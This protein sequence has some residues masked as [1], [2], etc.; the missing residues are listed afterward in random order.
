[1]TWPDQEY[2][3]ST[4]DKLISLDKLDTRVVIIH[5]FKSCK[6][7]E[8]LI[9]DKVKTYIQD[10]FEVKEV[11][12]GTPGVYSEKKRLGMKQIDIRHF[13]L[14]DDNTEEGKKWNEPI[15][16]ELKN[17]CNALVSS[18]YRGNNIVERIMST[19]STCLR[20]H[21]GE[22]D[23]ANQLLLEGRRNNNKAEYRLRSSHPYYKQG[24]I[25]YAVNNFNYSLET[26]ILNPKVDFLKKVDDL[27][28]IMELPGSISNLKLQ[29]KDNYIIISGEKILTYPINHDSEIKAVKYD[30]KSA[31]QQ[32]IMC[33]KFE[34]KIPLPPEYIKITENQIEAAVQSKGIWKWKIKKPIIRKSIV[35]SDV[36]LEVEPPENGNENNIIIDE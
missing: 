26:Q 17:I 3:E 14:I 8:I 19:L 5:N 11:I 4:I 33:G 10:L 13:C 29:L 7:R 35:L 28:L 31:F 15:F 36:V 1:M 32:E 16:L 25:S 30:K 18:I 27:Y 34:K 24:E 2:I 20:S 6:T 21:T 9:R 22:P 23:S 12:S